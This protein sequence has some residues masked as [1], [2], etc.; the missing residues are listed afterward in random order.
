MKE[1]MIVLVEEDKKTSHYFT[2]KEGIF[3]PMFFQYT[4][5][6]VNHVSDGVETKIKAR[7]SLLKRQR[8]ILTEI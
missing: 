6:Q 4:L 8:F 2:L 3:C 7:T 5:I 1:M